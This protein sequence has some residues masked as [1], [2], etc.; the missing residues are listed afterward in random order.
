LHSKL[1]EVPW[2]DISPEEEMIEERL[3]ELGYLK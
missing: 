2:L 1:Y 3:R